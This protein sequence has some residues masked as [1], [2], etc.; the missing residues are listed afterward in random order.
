MKRFFLTANIILGLVVAGMTIANISG[1]RKKSEEYS[2]KKSSKKT[3][4]FSKK[5]PQL[6]FWR[7]RIR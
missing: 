5:N 3:P 4:P 2:V 1:P 7:L 6:P